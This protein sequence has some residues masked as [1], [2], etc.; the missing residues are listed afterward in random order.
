M[1]NATPFFAGFHRLLFGTPARSAID[2]LQRQAEDLRR[3]SLCQLAR[4]FEPWL[5]PEKLNAP[6][7]SRRRLFP[8]RVTFWAFLS[9]V[10][11]P[12]AS[13][14]EALGK[15]QAWCA[16]HRIERP[17]SDTG[18]YCKARQRLDPSQLRELHAHTAERLQAGIRSSQLWCGR[19]V[20]VVDGTGVSMP[21]TLKNQKAFP[22]PSSQKA[23]CGFPVAH[24]TACFCLASG[25]LVDWAEGTLKNHEYSLLRRLWA[26][27]QPGDILL[28]D[29][30]F[31]AFEAIANFVGRGVDSV[32]RL[33]QARCADFRF[34]K[35]IRK[36][37]RLVSW[38]KPRKRPKECGIRA[39]K[40]LPSELGLRYVKI[41]VA[42]P[43]FRTQELIVVTTLLDPEEYSAEAI[44]ELYLRRWGVELFFRDIKI[45][46]GMDILRC[47]SPD[48][49]RKEII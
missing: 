25:A 16:L 21:D 17:D 48:M 42:T 46:L 35:R 13:C 5:P 27:F 44:G 49:V 29:R 36:N 20:K 37:E 30:G 14:R 31:C 32:V 26:I 1:K 18:A 47:K 7:G 10:L 45:S 2:R 38:T 3:A 8:V 15:V 23:G 41:M 43:G 39:W 4:L 22:Q 24:I 9:Q 6:P 40:K 34:G 12:A 19:R 28:A 33:H 11:S